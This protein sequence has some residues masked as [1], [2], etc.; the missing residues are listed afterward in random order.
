MDVFVFIIAI[1]LVITTMIMLY[2]MCEHNKLRT[3]VMSLALQQVK[4]LSASLIK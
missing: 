4:E 3:L 1:I 2:I